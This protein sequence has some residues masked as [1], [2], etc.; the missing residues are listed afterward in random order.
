MWLDLPDLVAQHL[1]RRCGTPHR[2]TEI[3]TPQATYGQLCSKWKMGW[4]LTDPVL[5]CHANK[6]IVIGIDD[7][8]Q[9]LLAVALAIPTAVD[10]NEYWEGGG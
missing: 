8:G 5:N 10:P 4:R 2:K 3:Q 1:P 7:G 6:T 9:V